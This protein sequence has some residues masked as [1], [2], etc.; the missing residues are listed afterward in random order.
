MVEEALTAD[1]IIAR[2]RI[3]SHKVNNISPWS[4]K[5]SSLSVNSKYATRLKIRAA[6]IIQALPR[7]E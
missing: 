5:L 1:I 4:N 6:A 7:H 2:A 3:T